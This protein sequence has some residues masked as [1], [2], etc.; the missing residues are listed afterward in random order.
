MNAVIENEKGE[1]LICRMPEDRGA[2]PGQWAI[3]GGGIDEGEKM[4]E[5]LYRE[6]WEETG[7]KIG[8]VEAVHFQDAER[9]KLNKD[10]SREE[11]YMVHLVFKAK[12]L[13]GK[14]K[15]NEEFD[16]YAWVQKTRLNEYDLNEATRNTF[17]VRGFIKKR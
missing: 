6:I 11:V 2:Y 15:I 7:L 10:G 13:G 16:Q 5:A 3:P 17:K 12:S 1:I 8:E 9:E 4:E 14:V